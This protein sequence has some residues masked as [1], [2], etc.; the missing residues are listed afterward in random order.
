MP[1]KRFLKLNSTSIQTKLNCDCVWNALFKL[2]RL[3]QTVQKKHGATDL[4]PSASLNLPQQQQQLHNAA[5][6]QQQFISQ[7]LKKLQDSLV[8]F[9]IEESN[10]GDLYVYTKKNE[11]FLLK[12]EEVCEVQAAAPS[13]TGE[14]A[15]PVPNDLNPMSNNQG[16]SSF[17]LSASYAKSSNANSQQ[18]SAAVKLM[19]SNIT[20][21]PSF[22]SIDDTDNKGKFNV[23]FYYIFI[24]SIK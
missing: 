5:A 14:T 3:H 16:E 7:G 15:I 4:T 19:N 17:D 24:Y 22:A 21:R 11:I 6:Q 18:S 23:L 2:H 20:R 9:R 12:L 1:I 8:N 13:Y 10:S